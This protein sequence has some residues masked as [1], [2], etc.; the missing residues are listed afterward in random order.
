M[1]LPIPPRGARPGGAGAVAL[2][3]AVLVVGASATD[4]APPARDA[5]PRVA[6]TVAGPEGDRELSGSIVVAAADGGMLLELDD[7]R[8]EIVRPGSVRARRV[9]EA[10]STLADPRALGRGI[11]AELPEGFTFLVT[12]HYVVCFDTPR[13]YAEWCAALFE[14]L[15]AAFLAHWTKVGVEVAAPSEPL[16]VVIFA[17][18]GRYE[19]F[20]AA[21]LG[22]AKGRVAGYYDARTNRVTTFDLTR[23]ESLARL[24][25]T[26][27]TRAGLQIL[28]RPEAAGLVST[29][30]HEASHQM[31]F[32][33]G[34]HRRLAP[35]PLWV[36]EGMATYCERGWKEIGEVNKPLLD[37]FLAGYRPGVLD[38]ILDSDAPFRDPDGMSQAYARAWALT[39]F[40]AD[41]RGDAF[42]AYMATLGAKRPLG[43]DGPESRRRDF[44]AAFGAE[45][46]DFEEELVE[47]VARLGSRRDAP[48]RPWHRPE[49]NRPGL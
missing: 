16:V 20:A 14:R 31:A 15:H 17:D 45:P 44:L 18:R 11:V 22:A 27:A 47:Y 36:A 35:V 28:A 38:A 37:R 26:S 40:L 46:R 4:A 29:L 10:P 41:T 34:L 32:N 42:A 5:P 33:C 30:V 39:A 12:E 25:P 2:L 48:A 6:L 3:V 49:G 43:P 8:L 21:D 19:T 13:P 1:S 23:S 9:L 24:P 7:Q